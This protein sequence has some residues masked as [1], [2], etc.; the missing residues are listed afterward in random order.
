MPH[1]Y[2]NTP[3]LT[4]LSTL[5][6]GLT[7]R[8]APARLNWSVK[9]GRVAFVKGLKR[10]ETAEETIERLS[11][12][13]PEWGC[14][15]WLGTLSA[16]G[17]AKFTYNDETGKRRIARV[18]RYL[19]RPIADDLEVDHLCHQRWCVNPDHLEPVTHLENIR[20]HFAWKVAN[21]QVC[22]KHGIPLRFNGKVRICRKCKTEYQQRW[23]ALR[24]EEQGLPPA[25]PHKGQRKFL[26]PD[27]GSPYVKIGNV[28]GRTG[29]YGCCNCGRGFPYRR[30]PGRKRSAA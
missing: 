6:R 24:R 18:T 29:R 28:T 2:V 12:P 10:A 3:W 23:K 7:M 5:H 25:A 13:I 22:E 30:I 16:S 17:Y 26:C 15:A 11:M 4:V 21:R 1:V 20:R 14:Y 27:C 19:C 9:E 8:A